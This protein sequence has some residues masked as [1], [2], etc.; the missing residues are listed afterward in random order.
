LVALDRLFGTQ[1]AR[2]TLAGWA[3]T[4][5]SDVPFFL[6]GGY[7]CV[8][9]RGELVVPL[10]SPY[11]RAHFVVVVPPLS[12]STPEVFGAWDALHPG[13][14]APPTPDR[15]EGLD[16]V[17]DLETP[18]CARYPALKT[19][20][21]LVRSAPTPL[22]G[23]SGSGSAWYAAFFEHDA[24]LNYCDALR[25]QQPQATVFLAAARRAFLDPHGGAGYDVGQRGEGP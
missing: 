6:C 20:A 16:V 17:N 19:Y 12:A 8:R 15:C 13:H 23:M 7:A 11:E 4:L 24:A 3:Q 18:A 14:Q 21:A 1:L 2:S 25:L 9:G 10:A 22:R 5:G